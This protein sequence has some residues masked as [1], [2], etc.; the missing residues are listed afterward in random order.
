[1]ADDGFARFRRAFPDDEAC[2]R[3]VA[4][5][6]GEDGGRR[7]EGCGQA[8]PIIVDQAA[9]TCRCR[10]CGHLTRPRAGTPFES[11]TRPLAEWLFALSHVV[12][13]AGGAS[14]AAALQSALGYGYRDAWRMEQTLRDWLAT[15]GAAA[16]AADWRRLVERRLA[17][18]SAPRTKGREAATPALARHTGRWR[19][20]AIA[21]VV[22]CAAATGGAW[23]LVREHGVAVVAARPSAVTV[24]GLER[25]PAPPRD[26]LLLAALAP[27]GGSA[28][29]A[30]PSEEAAIPGFD[31]A[32]PGPTVKLSA[33]EEAKTPPDLAQM[34]SARKELYAEVTQQASVTG[35]RN[36]NEIL[37]FGSARVPR[38]V[39]DAVMKGARQAN[40]DPVLLLAIADR[41]SGFVIQAHAKTSSASGLFQFIEST[42]LGVVRDFGAKY[43][44]AKEAA[45]IAAGH[46]DPTER[47]RIL[48]LRSDPYLATVFVA[49][50]LRRDGMRIAKKLGRGLTGGEVYSMHFLGADAAERLIATASNRPDVLAAALLPRPAEANKSVFY[51]PGGAARTAVELNQSLDGSITRL[52]AIFKTAS[53]QAGPLATAAAPPLPPDLLDL[54]RQPVRE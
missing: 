1:M 12:A 44:L 42:W 39:F 33:A 52:M 34:M 49:E 35:P 30:A 20:A 29:G 5:M 16:F 28:D 32:P 47:A 31:S 14:A 3:A 46:L 22:L 48:D 41:E 27:T 40:V 8:A 21:A 43:G 24:A 26:L 45:L 37:H 15:P 17:D 51:K 19:A 13:T 9:R 18:L 53:D 6:H 54:S 36:P 4:A 2:L 50:M 38:A 25:A 10:A 11:G 7:C 23:I